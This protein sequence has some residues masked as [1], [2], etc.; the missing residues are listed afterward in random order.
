MMTATKS[1]RIKSATTLLIAGDIL[2]FL[3]FSL[4]G[5][6]DHDMVINTSAVLKTAAPFIITWLTIGTLLGAFKP[7]ATE[8]FIPALL[9]VTITWL[10]AGTAGVVLRSLLLGTPV[11]LLFLGITLAANLLPFWIW[12]ASFVWINRRFV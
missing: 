6:I 4:L 5:R 3:L 9:W 2:I 11:N 1:E 12:R 8:R 10:V 7:K